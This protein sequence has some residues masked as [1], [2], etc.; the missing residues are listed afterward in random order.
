[1]EANNPASS[2]F[3]QIDKKF[4]QPIVTPILN[5]IQKVKYFAL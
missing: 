3:N 5:R 4:I 2:L 1:M